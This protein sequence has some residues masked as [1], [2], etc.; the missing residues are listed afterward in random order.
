VTSTENNTLCGGGNYQFNDTGNDGVI[1]VMS[2]NVL[3]DCNGTT[4]IGNSSGRGIVVSGSRTNVTIRNCNVNKYYQGI[5]A[6][7][8]RYLI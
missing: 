7:V 3:L 4:I 5:R 2:D 1:I 8:V 6:N